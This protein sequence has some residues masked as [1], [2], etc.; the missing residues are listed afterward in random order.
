MHSKQRGLFLRAVIYFS[1]TILDGGVKK[2]I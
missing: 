2:R 1:D